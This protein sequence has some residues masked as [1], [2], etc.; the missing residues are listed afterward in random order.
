M[1]I[2]I[3]AYISVFI[4]VGMTMPSLVPLYDSGAKSLFGI[5]NGTR[6]RLR[7][8]HYSCFFMAWY[9]SA[10]MAAEYNTMLL[11]GPSVLQLESVTAGI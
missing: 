6:G 10:S 1:I 11:N 2:S 7:Y 4:V 3:L 9:I 5:Q 8:M